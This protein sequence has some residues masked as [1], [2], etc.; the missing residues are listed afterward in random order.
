MVSV[1][2]GD[3]KLNFFDIRLSFTLSVYFDLYEYCHVCNSCSA[4]PDF[5]FQSS[6]SNII[7]QC[8]LIYS[9]LSH[10]FESANLCN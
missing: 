2:N 4:V 6:F 7:I 3:V 1:L 5:E 9:M 8:H 10:L